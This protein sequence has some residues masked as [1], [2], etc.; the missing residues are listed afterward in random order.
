MPRIEEMYAYIA[1]DQEPGDEGIIGVQIRDTMM[2]LVGADI[3]RSQELRQAA[4]HVA[5]MMGKPVTLVKFS[6]RH[7]L[8]VLKPEGH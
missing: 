6:R 7:E 2:P 1:D 8:L 5:N 3:E 4:Q